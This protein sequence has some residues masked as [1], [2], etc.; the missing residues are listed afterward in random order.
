MLKTDI[1]VPGAPWPPQNTQEAERLNRIHEN[2]LLFH[3]KLDK[4]NPNWYQR[5]TKN[6]E[7]SVPALVSANLYKTLTLLCA[8]LLY[9]EQGELMGASCVTD[10]TNDALKKIITDTLFNLTAY[11]VG[12]IAASYRGDGIYAISAEPIKKGDV[13]GPKKVCIESQPANYWFPIVDQNSVKRINRHVIAWPIYYNNRVYLRKR[14]H[15]IGRYYDFAFELSGYTMDTSDYDFKYSNVPQANVSQNGKIG[16]QVSLDKVGMEGAPEAVDTKIDNF[17]VVHCQNWGVDNNVYGVDDYEDLD[18]LLYELAIMI[19]RNSMVL[20]KHT[21]PN[22]YGPVDNLQ[23][24]TVTGQYENKVGGAFYPVSPEGNPPGYLTWDGKLDSAEKQIDRLIQLYM[25][26]S[27][28]SPAI[29]NLDKFGSQLSGSALRK[30]MMLTLQK[31]NRK[32]LHAD[33]A[34]K[35]VLEIAQKMDVEWCSG[36]YEVERPTL[37]WQDGLPNDDV[38]TANICNGRVQAGTL[39]KVSAIMRMDGVTEEKANEELERIQKEQDAALP[40]F[41]RGAVKGAGKSGGTNRTGGGD[42]GTTGEP[43]IPDN[44]FQRN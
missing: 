32:K 31:I 7:S 28:V 26:V 12:G 11:Q 14:V 8:D 24:N 18:E 39:S 15:E 35:N 43:P 13:N 44:L 36:S 25:M 16:S 17:L 40:G 20:S 10:K 33:P 2:E 4:V 41:A 29:F 9:G 3:N 38:E 34:I 42:Q 23:Y 6:W 1:I 30:L 22:M 5:V 27:G 21:D 19:S 37:I